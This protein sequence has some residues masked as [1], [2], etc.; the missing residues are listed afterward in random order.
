MKN[1]HTDILPTKDAFSGGA[2][3][4]AGRGLAFLA[5]LAVVT[6]MGTAIP[7]HIAGSYT[8]VMATLTIL[9][10]AT[11]PGMNS[12]LSRATAQGFEGSVRVMM[13]LRLLWGLIGSAGSIAIAGYYF[14]QGNTLLG[15][16]F[17]VAAPFIPLT[18]TFSSITF[19]YWQGK[20]RFSNSALMTF[21]YYLTL[22]ALSIPIFLLTD[23]LL[24]IVLGILTSQALAGFL[25]FQSVAKKIGDKPEPSSVT[26]GFHLTAMQALQIFAG[27]IDRVIVWLLLGP[28][29]TAVYTFASLPI[30]KAWQLV[31]I[32]VVT[33]PHL[34]TH[35]FTRNVQ[36][37]IMKKTLRLLAITIPVTAL[38]ITIA[39]TVY[40]IVF[41]LYPDSVR[42]FQLL[43][44][45]LALSPVLLL[46]SSLTAFKKTR[47]LYVIEF[48]SPTVKIVF[49]IIGGI[50]SGLSGIA[51]GIIAA[52]I[53]DFALAFG[54][55]VSSTPEDA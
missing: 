13:R 51:I 1:Q 2:Y 25:V 22:A 54:L 29:M 43:A 17:L 31:P 6:V 33:I 23:N 24:I 40:H 11:L 14:I 38:V 9:S 12:A 46:K 10:I 36:R 34:S 39:P 26:L 48:A 44:V 19:A 50:L 5:S 41:P 42:Y 55:F 28:A 21:S 15:Y 8:F 35:V 16:T 3:M 45:P 7:R 49:M 20:K 53:I 37:T 27:N 52:S 32:G 47:V 30:I 18:D 4:I